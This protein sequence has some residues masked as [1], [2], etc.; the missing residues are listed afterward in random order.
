[1]D[2]KPGPDSVIFLAEPK[3]C[4]IQFEPLTTF[5]IKTLNLDLK[6]TRTNQNPD[7]KLVILHDNTHGSC[8]NIFLLT[9]F[10]REAVQNTYILRT[11]L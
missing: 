10:L 3:N 4:F 2:L 5:G 7:Q 1:M 8:I 6:Q 9:P 11:C